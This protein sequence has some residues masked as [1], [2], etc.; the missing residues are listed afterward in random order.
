MLSTALEG[1]IKLGNLSSTLQLHSKCDYIS[2]AASCK[3]IMIL[4]QNSCAF[5]CKSQILLQCKRLLA[6]VQGA[7]SSRDVILL[8]DGRGCIPLG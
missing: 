6:F 3:R 1:I 8:C 7:I 4:E 5:E 2:A